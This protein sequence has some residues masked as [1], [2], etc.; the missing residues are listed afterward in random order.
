LIFLFKIESVFQKKYYVG[1][2]RNLDNTKKSEQIVAGQQKFLSK[3]ENEGFVIKR[4]R[5]IYDSGELEYADEETLRSASGG[6]K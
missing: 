1:I 5:V 2:A 3:I 6:R 4:G